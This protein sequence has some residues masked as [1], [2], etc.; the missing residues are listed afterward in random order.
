VKPRSLSLVF[1]LLFL[2]SCNW[3]SPTDPSDERSAS[4]TGVVK[5]AYD[6][7]WGGVS[8]GMVTE[9]GVA[10]SALTGNDGRYRI[11]RLRPGHYRVWLQL[12]RTGPGGYV[13]EID[14]Q[15]GQNTFDIVT[16]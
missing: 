2:T 8:V 10:A 5:N 3:L 6:S 13:G 7:V 12:G 4:I 15:P 11:R 1:L 9:T 16:H 14:L